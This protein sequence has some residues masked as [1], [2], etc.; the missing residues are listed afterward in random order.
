MLT[1]S[2]RSLKPATS[3][4][5]PS[6]KDLSVS[7]FAVLTRL[8]R[9][10]TSEQHADRIPDLRRKVA[11]EIGGRVHLLPRV[12]PV[13]D[14]GKSRRLDEAEHVGRDRHADVVTAAHQLPTDGGAGLDIAATSL[15]RNTIFNPGSNRLNLTRGDAHT[16]ERKCAL[17]GIRHERAGGV[18]ARWRP[19][20]PSPTG[21]C[22]LEF[23][24]VHARGGIR[25]E[26]AVDI[27][28]RIVHF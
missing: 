1:A 7:V 12:G 10:T 25:P 11:D 16:F 17:S 4:S 5:A 6:A 26:G 27:L 2:P 28:R 8:T 24:C 22:P 13:A 9:S 14:C 18:T 21:I 20:P 23:G 3:R 15:A 19:D